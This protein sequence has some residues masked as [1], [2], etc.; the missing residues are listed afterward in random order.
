MEN[1]ASKG[2]G[3]NKIVDIL[4]GYKKRRG[5]RI[6]YR[7]ENTLHVVTRKLIDPDM[8]FYYERIGK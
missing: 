4:S 6:M 1:G 7:A 8:Y 2:L 5:C 3:I